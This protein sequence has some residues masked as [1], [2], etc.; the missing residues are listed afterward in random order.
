MM[1]WEA[2]FVLFGKEQLTMNAP[3]RRATERLLEASSL[4]LLPRLIYNVYRD[5][6]TCTSCILQP[7]QHAILAWGIM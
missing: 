3:L 1:I 2:F 7:R 6:E 5:L 4:I